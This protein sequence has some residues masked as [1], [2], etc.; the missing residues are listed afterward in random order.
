MRGSALCVWL[1]S[2][3][4]DGAYCAGFFVAVALFWAFSNSTLNLEQAK[5]GYGFL[6]S[7]A[8][9]GAIFGS[10]L[11]TS[12]VHVSHL[13]AYGG[14]G[15][16]L[17][18]VV[19]KIYVLYFPPVYMLVKHHMPVT[20]QEQQPSIFMGFMEGLTL[21]FRYSYVTGLLAIDCLFDVVLTM[22]DYEMKVRAI[23]PAA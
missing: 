21:V 9:L 19:M 12:E 16:L 13:M 6:I 10:T 8:Q 14:V 7:V 3:L 18:A 17:V 20:K 5:A 23:A 15:A 4:L 1:P 22:L 2:A 11:V